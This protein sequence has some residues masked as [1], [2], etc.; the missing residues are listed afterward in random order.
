MSQKVAG[1][2][3]PGKEASPTGWT[4]VGRG[5]D[6]GAGPSDLLHLRFLLGMLYTLP[7]CSSG[8]CCDSVA[9]GGVIS[10]KRLPG[11][12][13]NGEVFEVD[14]QVVLEALPLP[15]N[16]AFPLC[17]FTIEELFWNAVI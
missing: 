5:C 16:F 3:N 11:L 17:Q 4:E 8:S 9:L 10:R 13:V 12:C 1:E 6:V 2:A 14:F 7:L 15:S